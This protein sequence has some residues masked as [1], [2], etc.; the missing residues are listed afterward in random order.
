MI[1]QIQK[2]IAM[3]PFRPFL[4]ET[5]GGTSVRVAKPEL[6][7]F[8]PE[9]G[10]LAVFEGAVTSLINFKDIRS[11]LIEQPPIPVKEELG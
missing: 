2:Q 6:I 11:V 1:E 3:R 9:L 4:I 10:Y 5:S 8:P 7:Y